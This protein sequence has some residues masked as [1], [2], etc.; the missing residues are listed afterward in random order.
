ML[1]SPLVPDGSAPGTQSPVRPERPLTRRELRELERATEVA[2]G[3]VGAVSGMFESAPTAGVAA[4][5]PGAGVAAP[6]PA[7]PPAAPVSRRASRAA[8][9]A[10]ALGGAIATGAPAVAA[11]AGPAAP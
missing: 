5:A 10:P 3:E 9:A 8:E 1:E 2:Q 4:P 6:A 7:G 11:A